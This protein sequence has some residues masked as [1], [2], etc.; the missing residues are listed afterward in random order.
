MNTY[1]L[2]IIQGNSLALSL[3]INDDGGNPIDLSNSAV[4]GFVKFRYGDTGYLAN[5]NATIPSGTTGIISLNLSSIVTRNLPIT[6][7][8]YDIETSNTISNNVSKIL[9]GNVYINPTISL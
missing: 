5:L 3:T 4:S 6:I 7:G 8:F 2:Q 9:A 1:D